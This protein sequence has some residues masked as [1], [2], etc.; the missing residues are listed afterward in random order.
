MIGFLVVFLKKLKEIYRM[1]N[2]IIFQK[3]TNQL[4]NKKELLGLEVIRFISALAVLITHYNFFFYQSNKPLDFTKE[5]MPFYSALSFFYEYGHY[6]VHFFWTISGFIFFYKYREIISL[7]L[8]TYKNFFL[9][10]FSRLYPLHF[11]TL[12]FVIILQA[13]Y[14]FKKNYFYVYQNNDIE[15]FTY[16]LFLASDWGFQKGY[17]FNGPIWSVSVEIL[18]YCFFFLFLKNVS[19]SFIVNLAIVFLYLLIK[20][21]KITKSPIL[22]C[23]VFFYLGGLSAISF[24]YL[25][26]KKFIKSLYYF[27][28]FFLLIVPIFLYI[29]KIYQ[30]KYIEYLFLMLYAPTACF[31]CAQ[32]FNFNQAS[33]IAKTIKIGGNITY[34]IYLIHF[35]FQLFIVLF[36]FNIEQKIPYYSDAFF[37]AYI[38]ATL[39]ISYYIYKLFELPVQK[40][41]RKK[42]L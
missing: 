30:Q 28:L 2:K 3:K 6:G 40:F 19:K 17:S 20:Y 18:V 14:F 13:I 15:H 12:L 21:L 1:K 35:P 23:L 9:L 39:I 42:L 11:L 27:C 24:E 33:L 37:I 32:N 16:Q 31:F 7:N 22:D 34:S 5:Q 10:R 26:E 38:F 4:I 41:I 25:K 36:F 8:I 29:T